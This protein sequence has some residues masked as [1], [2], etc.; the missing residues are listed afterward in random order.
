MEQSHQSI[1]LNIGNNQF[2]QS[3]CNLQDKQNLSTSMY[4]D[5]DDSQIQADSHLKND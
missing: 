3:N 2:D 5:D 4:V 1:N